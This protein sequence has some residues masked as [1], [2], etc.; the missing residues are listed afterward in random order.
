MSGDFGRI[1]FTYWP[2]TGRVEFHAHTTDDLKGDGPVIEVPIKALPL[3]SQPLQAF[4]AEAARR[5]RWAQSTRQPW[6]KRSHCA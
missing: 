2:R 1:D 4:A 6:P 3:V 5:K